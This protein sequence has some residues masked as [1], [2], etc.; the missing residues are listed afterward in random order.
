MHKRLKQLAVGWLL[1]GLV[2]AL[3][4]MFFYE[5][6]FVGVAIGIMATTY[7]FMLL[8]ETGWLDKQE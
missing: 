3:I 6:F 2:A 8:L 4:D 5:G 1:F 7:S